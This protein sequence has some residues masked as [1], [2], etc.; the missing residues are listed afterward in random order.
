LPTADTVKKAPPNDTSK[1][2]VSATIAP[3][4]HDGADLTVSTTCR[5][6]HNRIFKYVTDY[7]LSK[8]GK[9]IAFAVTAPAKQKD[10]THQAC[11]FLTLIKTTVKTV[12]TGRG[13]YHVIS[14]L[15]MR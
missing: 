12:S 3:P 2:A 7:Q 4:T 11:M 13:N 5:A 6:K 15:M 14:P 10:S 9:L 1:K 8:N